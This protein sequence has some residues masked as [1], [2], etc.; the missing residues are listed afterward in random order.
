MQV[1]ITNHGLQREIVKQN[2]VYVTFHLIT[3]LNQQRDVLTVN[4]EDR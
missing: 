2:T 3:N 4:L 1:F